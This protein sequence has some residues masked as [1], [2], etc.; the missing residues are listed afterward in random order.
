MISVPCSEEAIKYL[1]TV[2]LGSVFRRF[3]INLSQI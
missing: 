1:I 2:P 3:S